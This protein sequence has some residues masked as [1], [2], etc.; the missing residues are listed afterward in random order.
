M[1]KKYEPSR[2][3]AEP[4]STEQEP[5]WK[6]VGINNTTMYRYKVEIDNHIKL[7]IRPGAIE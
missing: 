7:E 5:S 2:N 1:K 4:S 3:R 6:R